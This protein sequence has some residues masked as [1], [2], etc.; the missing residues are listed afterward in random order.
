VLIEVADDGIPSANDLRVT[1]ADTL[2]ADPRKA[3]LRQV[4]E[5]LRGMN[6]ELTV[7]SDEAG[8]LVSL[9]LPTSSE[10]AVSDSG[11]LPSPFPQIEPRN[12]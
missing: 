8:T 5:R 4:R 3:R 1:L 2:F 12:H 9:Y 11:S 7:D 10:S 6:S